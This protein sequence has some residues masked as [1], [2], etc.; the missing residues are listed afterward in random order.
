MHPDDA[1]RYGIGPEAPC[2]VASER[3]AIRAHALVT[4]TV[5]QGCVFLP[6]HDARTN[7]LTMPSFDPHSR[8]PAYKHAAVS[9]RPLEH[10]EA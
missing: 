10:W 7:V 1:A 9:I 8:Q 6:M 3:G 2:E 5:P 4:A